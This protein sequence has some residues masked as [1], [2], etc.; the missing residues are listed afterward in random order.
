MQRRFRNR[1]RDRI[2]YFPKH[3]DNGRSLSVLIV[4]GWMWFEKEKG[5][6]RC[7]P[8]L[9]RSKDWLYHLLHKL[10]VKLTEV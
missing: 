8:H 7:I 5:H 10:T 1:N 2:Y 4:N 9:Q 6:T 3:I